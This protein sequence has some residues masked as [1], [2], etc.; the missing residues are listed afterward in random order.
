[1]IFLRNNYEK[2]NDGNIISIA[3][4][5]K[6]DPSAFTVNIPIH[7]MESYQILVA[8]K[9]LHLLT[10]E[11]EASGILARI[12]LIIDMDGLGIKHLTPTMLEYFKHL[13]SLF[14]LHFPETLQKAFI[15]NAPASFN[16][17]WKGIRGN[18]HPNVQKKIEILGKDYE[19]CIFK[20]FSRD[21]LPKIFK[22]INDKLCCLE[23]EKNFEKIE[24]SSTKEMII[25]LNN[26]LNETVKVTWDFRADKDVRVSIEFLPA[27]RASTHVEIL[28]RTKLESCKVLKGEFDAPER[29]HIRFVFKPT[30]IVGSTTLKYK[31]CTENR[32]AGGEL[33][34]RDSTPSLADEQNSP[35]H[36][37]EEERLAFYEKSHSLDY[38]K[39]N[40]FPLTQDVFKS[41]FKLLERK[42]NEIQ[43]KLEEQS[44]VDRRHFN[45]L[46]LLNAS[47]L[48]IISIL[49]SRTLTAMD[50]LTSDPPPLVSLW[51]QFLSKWVPTSPQ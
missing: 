12:V 42:L 1:M 9:R 8:A 51:N 32:S 47:V 46:L 50:R 6:V 5:G 34:E 48:I 28:P 17:V 25:K 38:N 44:R 30:Q 10:K 22:G 29:G 18:L 24:F 33:I 35:M 15:I 41:R 39:Q 19:D 14:Q 4:V 3:L 13:V 26:F 37:F 7:D 36:F 16:L 11:S 49:F 31:M 43:D 20:Q 45:Y 23:Y 21:Q 27:N 2:D 40:S